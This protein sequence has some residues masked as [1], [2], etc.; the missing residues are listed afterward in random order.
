ME[1][2]ISGRS[3][4]ATFKQ[5][6]S[7]QKELGLLFFALRVRTTLLPTAPGGRLPL[8]GPMARIEL[9]QA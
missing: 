6:C 7:A 3:R 4:F 8:S 2:S 1:G 5:P 9:I